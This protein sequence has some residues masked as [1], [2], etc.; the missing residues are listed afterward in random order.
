MMDPEDIEWHT[1]PPV[2][3]GGQHVGMSTGVLAVHKPTGIAIVRTNQRS[4][5]KNK[6]AAREALYDVLDGR[7]DRAG[8]D[9]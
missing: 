1:W 3:R 5:Y 2:P 6:E 7:P 8:Y 9:S 4:M